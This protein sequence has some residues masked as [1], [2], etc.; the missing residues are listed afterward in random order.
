VTVSLTY[1]MTKGFGWSVAYTHTY[2]TEV[3]PLTSSTSNSNFGPFGLQPERRSRCQLGLPG[4][5]PHQRPPVSFEKAFFGN[6]KTRFGMFYEGRSGKPY[7]WTFKNDLNGDGLATNDLMYIPK[8]FG[9]GEV[10]FFGDTATSHANEQRFW[11]IVNANKA[12][13]QFGKGGVV[14][15]NNDFSHRGPTASTCKISQEIPGCSLATRP[16]S[17]S[18]S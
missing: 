13:K 4:E 6:Y 5:G 11:D 17:R 9:S 10:T 1:P 15:R 14:G 2:A 7:S 8:A 18:T 16:A 3:S 12:L